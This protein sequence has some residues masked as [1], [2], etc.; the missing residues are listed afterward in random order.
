MSGVC[1]FV[2]PVRDID[3]AFSTTR[4][5]IELTSRL[6]PTLHAA[7]DPTRAL[8]EAQT[9]F[10][11]RAGRSYEIP[12]KRASKKFNYFGQSGMGDRG[13]KMGGVEWQLAISGGQ[14]R[15]AEQAIDLDLI[16]A[17]TEC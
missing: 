5:G 8:P 16:L 17:T 15:A 3:G 12:G 6:C 4:T 13:G 2:T 7:R 11:R 1:S 14:N 9:G 10:H